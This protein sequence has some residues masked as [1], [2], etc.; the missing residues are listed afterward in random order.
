MKIL[1]SLWGMS[2]QCVGRMVFVEAENLNKK[3]R[4]KLNSLAKTGKSIKFAPEKWLRLGKEKIENEPLY[5]GVLVGTVAIIG[6]GI[7]YGMDDNYSENTAGGTKIVAE[8]LNSEVGNK[9]NRLDIKG[10]EEASAP[11]QLR[12]PFGP[13]RMIDSPAK[14]KKLP[15]A[16]KAVGQGNIKLISTTAQPADKPTAKPIQAKQSNICLQGIVEMD[17]SLGALL[18]LGGQNK[19]LLAGESWDGYTV[20]NID[21]NSIQLGKYKLNIGDTIAL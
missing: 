12:N 9:R 1:G 20:E 17:G 5:R 11:T 7:I 19:F 10:M 3:I 14:E 8:N 4:E 15:K 2:K 13:N 16:D 18:T 21:K 6:I